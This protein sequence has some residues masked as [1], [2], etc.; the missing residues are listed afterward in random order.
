M[1]N[2]K[3]FLVILSMI[4]LILVSVF[5]YK[6]YYYDTI[7][8]SIMNKKWYKYDPITG[9]YESLYF[10]NNE[11]TYNTA[12]EN[13]EYSNC[14]KYTYDKKNKVFNLDC[15]NQI[16]I[17]SIKNNKLILTFNKNRQIF[18]NN[19]NDTL[20]YEFESFYKKNLSEV[21]KELDRVKQLVKINYNSL[22]EILSSE[23]IS[24]IYI[25]GNNC[26]SIDCTLV[27]DTM[28]KL[29]SKNNNIYYLNINSLT[30]MELKYLNNITNNTFKDDRDYY[31]DIYPKVLV[32]SKSLVVDEYDFICEGLKCNKYLD[33]VE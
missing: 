25:I 6:K 33:E 20:N 10:K 29:I 13:N 11:F 18:Y 28:E 5:Y 14:S 1:K 30:D 24:K 19:I 7:D 31:D 32:V 15:G 9:H 3:L 22:L 26:S 8:I 23:E 16:K 2:R 21:K 4:V 12:D 27:L 17:N